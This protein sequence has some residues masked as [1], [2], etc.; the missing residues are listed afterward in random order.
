MKSLFI[1]I[2]FLISPVRIF[3]QDDARDLKAK[4]ILRQVS[5]KYSK[6]SSIKASIRLIIENNQEGTTDTQKV[7]AWMKAEKYKLST[8]D[9]ETTSDGKTVWSYQK[10]SN[11]VNISEKDLKDDSFFSNPSQIFSN[12]ESNFK[13]RYHGEKKSGSGIICEIDL[14]PANLDKDVIQKGSNKTGYSRIRLEIDKTTY[15]IIAI[16]YFSKDGNYIIIEITRM[17]TDTELP[18][19]FFTFDPGKYAG[20]EIIDLRD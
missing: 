13:Y 7:T 5:A 6:Y 2:S 12:Y 11:E 18:D 8:T 15:N 17:T 16:T 20:I 4:E 3:A 19:T 14:F 10:K 1:I 9:I